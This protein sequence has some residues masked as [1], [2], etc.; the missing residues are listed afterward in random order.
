M[1]TATLPLAVAA[2]VAI[3]AAAALVVLTSRH[4]SITDPTNDCW[5]CG[6]P[7]EYCCC[8]P[9]D[10][11]CTAA[12]SATRCVDR[13]GRTWAT[14]ERCPERALYYGGSAGPDGTES[15]ALC[16]EHHTAHLEESQYDDYMDDSWL[17]E[18]V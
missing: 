13:D 2:L 17:Y 4:R 10:E 15:W 16:R 11:R 9:D 3:A 18:E 6:Y 12:V 5:S 14:G 1:F 7:L 8:L